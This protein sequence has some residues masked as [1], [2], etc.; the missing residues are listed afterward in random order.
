MCKLNARAETT[1]RLE[2]RLCLFVHAAFDRDLPGGLPAKEV[3]A[4]QRHR[5]IGPLR[6]AI[7]LP[8]PEVAQCKEGQPLQVCWP[9]FDCPPPSGEGGVGVAP[10]HLTDRESV[11]RFGEGGVERYGPTGKAQ[12]GLG[13]HWVD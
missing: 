11:P 3:I 12:L 1:R 8:P 5:A 9:D 13:V 7:V 2:R 6:S 10:V 4:I